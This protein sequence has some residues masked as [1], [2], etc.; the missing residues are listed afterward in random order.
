MDTVVVL[1]GQSGDT[2]S[3]HHN[4]II[5]ADDPAAVNAN[6]MASLGAND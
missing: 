5:L 4:S 2:H 6:A 1:P 3:H